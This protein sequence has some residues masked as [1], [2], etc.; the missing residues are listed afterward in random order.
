MR[1]GCYSIKIPR[2]VAG[3][4]LAVVTFQSDRDYPIASIG[5]V[6]RVQ[7]GERIYVS[8]WPDPEKEKDPITGDCRG[9]VARR[10]R[11]LAWTPITRKIEPDRGE[12]GYSLFY[13]DRTRPGMSG[14]PVFDNRGFLIGVHGRGSADQGKL[15]RQYCS[16]VVNSQNLE[17]ED[18]TKTV[19]EAVNYDPP[20]LHSIF[21]SGQNLNNFVSLLPNADLD[22]SL[23]YQSPSSDLIQAALTK[24]NFKE[25]ETGELDFDPQTDITGQLDLS[26]REDV[27]EDIYKGFSLKNMLRD[28]PSAGCRFLLLGEDCN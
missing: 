7:V 18:F 3:Q 5:N 25:L 16:S 28:K 26:D 19:S 23:Q 22:L 13:F 2:R 24:I 12:N 17:S 4:D 11:R 9:K 8:G 1:F 27:V 15:V 14:G 21:S 20:T 6:D 10:Q